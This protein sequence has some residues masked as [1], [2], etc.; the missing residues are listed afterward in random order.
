MMEQP[1]MVVP[2][3]VLLGMIF[4]APLVVLSARNPHRGYAI[5]IA[6]LFG[7]VP[8]SALVAYILGV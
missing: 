6:M 1:M 8:A 2:L 3:L 4:G 5:A 7:S